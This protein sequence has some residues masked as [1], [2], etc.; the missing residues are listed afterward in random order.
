MPTGLQVFTDLRREIRKTNRHVALLRTVRHD[1][2][3]PEKQPHRPPH[4]AVR[5]DH[6]LSF[7]AG[8]S[9]AAVRITVV[10]FASFTTKASIRFW[11]GRLNVSAFGVSAM[12]FS[13][14]TCDEIDDAIARHE[15]QTER[16]LS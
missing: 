16:A 1:P 8:A 12:N 15:C 10:P 7:G 13:Y 3:A 5:A 11:S 2:E 9:S 6:F 4:P 14:V